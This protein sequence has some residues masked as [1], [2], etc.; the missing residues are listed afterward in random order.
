MVDRA[1][2]VEI[3]IEREIGAGVRIDDRPAIPWRGQA[4]RSPQIGLAAPLAFA[5]KQVVP[6]EEIERYADRRLAELEAFGRREAKLLRAAMLRD[7]AFHPDTPPVLAGRHDVVD[8][9]GRGVGAIDGRSA[10]TQHLDARDQRGR[11]DVRVGRQRG[12]A[13]VG[14]GQRVRRQS[15]AVD[16]QQGAARP[17]P[18]Q[19]GRRD[20]AARALRGD[21]RL[22]DRG[23]RG[24]RQGFVQIG[25]RGYAAQ[26]QFGLIDDGHGQSRLRAPD[27][28]AGDDDF[29]RSRIG[30]DRCRRIIGPGSLLRMSTRSQSEHGH[31]SGSA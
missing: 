30:I 10:V 19:V 25:P 24:R 4:A 26:I 23:R 31:D 14:A 21:R 18:A 11:N 3:V 28:G 7:R 8:D 20:V 6:P 1:A 9:P 13:L 29:L 22:V 12:N 2:V 15:A 27:V 17:D 16:Q 5:E